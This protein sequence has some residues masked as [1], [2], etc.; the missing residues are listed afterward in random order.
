VVESFE[1][2]T[3]MAKKKTVKKTKKGAKKA[4]KE[5]IEK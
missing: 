3:R 4:K 5:P 2:S 1:G